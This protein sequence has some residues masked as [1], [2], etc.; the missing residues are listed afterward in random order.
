MRGTC[1]VIEARSSGGRSTCQP[2]LRFFL[3][4]KPK[5]MCNIFILFYFIISMLLMLTLLEKEMEI[6]L[7]MDFSLNYYKL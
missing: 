5:G 1:L 4:L 3:C 2:L 7:R 6:K